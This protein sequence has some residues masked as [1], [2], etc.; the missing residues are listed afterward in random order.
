M[1][2]LQGLLLL[3]VVTNKKNRGKGM[4]LALTD[5]RKNKCDHKSSTG[6]EKWF[7]RHVHVSFF[8]R[9]SFLQKT[10]KVARQVYNNMVTQQSPYKCV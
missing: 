7:D 5:R 3:P 9:E 4:R 6:I 2:G 1:I 8:R 10:K